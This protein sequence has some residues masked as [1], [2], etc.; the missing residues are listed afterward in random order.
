MH[1]EDTYR[2]YIADQN[3]EIPEDERARDFMWSVNPERY[4]GAR[5][6]LLNRKAADGSR[7]PLP[8]TVTL[9]HTALREFI[10]ERASKGKGAESDS[11]AFVYAT[12]QCFNR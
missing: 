8:D 7:A 2:R 4:A 11:L 9:M 1:F 6:M 3:P 5:N 12:R 10:P